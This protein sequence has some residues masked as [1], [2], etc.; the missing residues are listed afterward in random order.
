MFKEHSSG[1][2]TPNFDDMKGKHPDFGQ[3]MVV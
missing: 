3:E 2:K 1:V